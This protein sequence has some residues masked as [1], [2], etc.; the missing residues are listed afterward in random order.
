[1]LVPGHIVW[2]PRFLVQFVRE[3]RITCWYSVPSILAGMLEE[4]RMAQ[5]DYPSLRVI[6][7]AGEIFHA[8]NVARLQAAVPHA[9]CANSMAL[10]KPTWSHGTACGPASMDPNRCPSVFPA[11]T[12]Q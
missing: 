7:F 2:M 10:R 9:D 6:L 12:Q 3:A 11:P 5:D 1:M 8:P 4:G